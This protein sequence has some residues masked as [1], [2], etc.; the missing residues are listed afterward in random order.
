MNDKSL[1]VDERDS[2]FQKLVFSLAKKKKKAKKKAK[3]KRWT[4]EAP[5]A[6]P[7]GRVVVV[8]VVALFSFIDRPTERKGKER[9]REMPRRPLREKDRPGSTCV[10]IVCWRENYRIQKEYHLSSKNR[11]ENTTTI[12]PRTSLF[13]RTTKKTKTKT[14]L[15]LSVV[16]SSR[17]RRLRRKLLLLRF[18]FE[19][20]FIREREKE[21]FKERET[22]AVVS[23][24]E[25]ARYFFVKP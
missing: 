13:S 21:S 12:Y 4:E 8:V 6:P 10:E 18:F 14:P 15:S 1:L 16:V 11:K 9:K 17:R 23:S 2:K 20:D 22:L 5:V 19:R 24:T 3:K 7:D 25:N